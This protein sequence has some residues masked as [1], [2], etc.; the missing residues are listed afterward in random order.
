V[1][2]LTVPRR[3]QRRHLPPSVARLLNGAR[4][5]IETVNDQLTEQFGLARH[6]AHTFPGLCARLHTKRAA[7]TLCL[8]LNRLLGIADWLQIKGLAFPY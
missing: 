6:H 3:D 4:Q 2:L 1:R 7:H 8:S 5:I